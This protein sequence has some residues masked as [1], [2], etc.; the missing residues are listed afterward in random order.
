MDANDFDPRQPTCHRPGTPGK[1]AVLAARAAGG[2]PLF[3]A[4]DAGTPRA[5]GGRHV[6]GRP[7]R[8]LSRGRALGA[9][10]AEL[11]RLAKGSR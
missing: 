5:R 2:L 1:I 3:L 11:A 6:Q 4:G 8:A 10:L 9:A 7:A